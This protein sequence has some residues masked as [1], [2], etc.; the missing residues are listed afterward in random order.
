VRP[1]VPPD[2]EPVDRWRPQPL[3]P[4]DHRDELP[5]E[6]DAAGYVGPYLFPDNRRRRIPA[7]IYAVTGAVLVAA[8]PFLVYF[9]PIFET[10]VLKSSGLTTCRT[11][12]STCLM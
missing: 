11:I 5:S 4:G 2:D 7:V 10:T 8:V 12:S 3:D 1:V 6:L 9:T